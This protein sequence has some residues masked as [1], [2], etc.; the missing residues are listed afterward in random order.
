MKNFHLPLPEPTYTLLRAEAE[1]AQV[2]ATTIAREAIDAWL[3][4]RARKARHDAI[5]AYATEMAGTDLDLDRDLE[6]AGIS[7]L[8]KSGRKRK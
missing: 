1:R 6:S 2:P 4:S 8:V 5:A 7:Q 3:E